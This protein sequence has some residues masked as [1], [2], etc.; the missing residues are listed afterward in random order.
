MPYPAWLHCDHRHAKPFSG[1]FS[2]VPLYVILLPV[3]ERNSL[4]PLPHSFLAEPRVPASKRKRSEEFECVEVPDGD[5]IRIVYPHL[6]AK[7]SDC[8]LIHCRIM[9]IDAPE[10]GQWEE[11]DND[12]MN[13]G[14]MA[15]QALQNLI[16]GRKVRVVTTNDFSYE[17]TLVE[18]VLCEERDVA[19]W[20]VRYGYAHAWGNRY[21]AEQK[22]AQA[23]RRGR[24]VSSK[25]VNPWDW[26]LRIK[27]RHPDQVSSKPVNPRDW[28]NSTTNPPSA[29]F[30]MTRQDMEKHQA[31]GRKEAEK[32]K[33][34]ST[35]PLHH[36][37]NYNPK[38]AETRQKTSG[39]GH[40]EPSPPSQPAALA[41]WVIPAI[42]LL[43]AIFPMPYGYYTMLRII[44]CAAGLYLAWREFNKTGKPS[45]WFYFF[46]FC[47]VLF[48]PILPVHLTREIWLPINL[49]V[50]GFFTIHYFRE[51]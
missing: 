22:E 21:R 25:P 51:L 28:R 9:H 40:L 46:G 18:L 8:D 49:T 12:I 29:K 36:A 45:R 35:A 27:C 15:K 30:L 1:E 2:E 14:E 10:Y 7:I 48:N 41:I 23:R 20:M 37:G 5:D 11:V 17:R 39:F 6:E 19:R 47:A 13:M 3:G 38:P 34:A 32:V 50:S 16:E 4:P 24:W 43:V 33:I 26:R 44:I 31:G 42:A